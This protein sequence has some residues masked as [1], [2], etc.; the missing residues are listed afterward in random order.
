MNAQQRVTLVA[1]LQPYV[2]YTQHAIQLVR[3]LQKTAGVHVAIRPLLTDTSFGAELPL[4]IRSRIVNGIQPE[5]WEIMLCPPHHRPTPGKQ[6]IYWTMWES[7]AL[8]KKS[9]ELLNEADVVIVPCRWCKDN[10]EASGVRP[11]IHV[12][13]LGVD[14]SI[15]HYRPWPQHDEFVFGAAGRMAHGGVRKGLLGVIECFTEAFRLDPSVRLRIKCYPDCNLPDPKDDRITVLRGHLTDEALADWLA[16]LDCF[17]SGATAEGWGLWQHQASAIGRPVL[18]AVYGGLADF[19]GDETS[20][21]V[22]YYEERAK[23]GY[24]GHGDWAEP[25]WTHMI[26]VMRNASESRRGVRLIGQAASEAVEELTWQ[27]SIDGLISVMAGVGAVTG[28]RKGRA[29]V[30]YPKSTRVAL[31]RLPVETQCR[32]AGFGYEAFETKCGP[33]EVAY[34]PSMVEWMLDTLTFYRVGQL[35]K[36]D[37][38]N[39]RIVV[40]TGSGTDPIPVDVGSNVEDPKAFVGSLGDLRL[41]YSRLVR[42]VTVQE[43]AALHYDEPR[44]RFT[45]SDV[46]VPE[47][48]GNGRGQQEKNWLWFNQGG[49]WFCIYTLE[50]MTVIAMN[51][52]G[53][54]A[55]LVR[56]NPRSSL[57]PYGIVRGSAPP[58]P[59]NEKSYI[60]FFHSALPWKLRRRRY[61]VGA[62]LFDRQSPFNI[63]HITP[64]PLLQGYP[65][66]EAKMGCA[67]CCVFPGGVIDMPADAMPPAVER[68]WLI[69]MGEND[70]RC[71]RVRISRKHIEKELC[72]L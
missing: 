17:V 60:A 27:N 5:E 31:E 34:N 29:P 65:N 64:F 50:P 68:G 44:R 45:A 70:E 3:W 56:H 51:R 4:D 67:H 28:T 8:P 32:L 9:V 6:T 12:V 43:F 22:H 72:E 30:P 23:E 49:Q 66:D 15:F 26:S 1:G 54:T 16:G 57:W 55:S 36:G 61:Y 24:A 41:A 42:G 2:G 7:T 71:S 39:S 35:V 38:R 33:R 47:I 46:W 19:L 40:Q 53:T 48:G 14:P 21:P 62:L 58:V 20:L 59:W 63:T 18:G 25:N 10:F 11:P 37:V 52:D 13:P 69:C